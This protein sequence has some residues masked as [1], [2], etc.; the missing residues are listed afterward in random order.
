MS[1]FE[2]IE[3]IEK[4]NDF[5]R[6]TSIRENVI[7]WYD[8][9]KDS[10]ILE[11]GSDFGQVSK[12]FVRNNFDI[13]S[14]EVDE[15]R[16]EYINSVIPE[17]SKFKLLNQNLIEFKNT[18]KKYDYILITTSMS[19]IRDFVLEEKKQDA[20]LKLLE[21][22]YNLLKENGI[23]LLATD[24]K[25][26]IRI[27]SGATTKNTNSYDILTG[28]VK[29][30]GVFSKKEIIK[31]IE[32]SSFK[33]YKFYYPF[34]DYKLPSVIYSDEY[35]PNKNSSKLSYLLYYNPEDTI[36]FNEAEVLKEIIKD[37]MPD[38]FSNSYI[39]EIAKNKEDFCKA[40]FVSFNNF[41][42]KTSK[43]ITKIYTDYVEKQSIF[44]EGKEHIENIRK[45]IEILEKCGFDVIDEVIDKKLYSKFQSIDNLNDILS[46]YILNDNIDTALCIID[47][48][49]NYIKEKFNSII[50]TDNEQISNNTVFEKYNIDID[51]KLKEELTFLKD[52]F[53]DIIFENIFT[54]LDS[55]NNFEK[56][57]VY[58]QEWCEKNLPL[59]FILYRAINNLFYYNPKIAK[60]LSI[61]TLY[62]RYKIEKFV[63]V[64]KVLEEKIQASLLDTYISNMYKS[65]YTS[66]TTLEALQETIY[67]SKISCQDIKKQYE[68]FIKTVEKTNAQWQVA[69]DESNRKIERL[70]KKLKEQNSLI[71]SFKN[72]FKK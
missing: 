65:T 64:F 62:N 51:T 55:S 21:I 42:K 36:V 53:F 35:L 67:Y 30:T 37:G 19:R 27:F 45:Y 60:C 13:T 52:G 31:L 69:L 63:D 58:D 2:N 34:P 16:C 29:D 10:S 17:S 15:K 50:I 22:S 70:E 3:L 1:R 56:F 28:K 24:N 66:L 14:L 25:Y 44:E 20:F 39:I 38:Y 4:F 61:E 72:L 12:F 43:M 49:Y 5:L 18:D 8:F 54:K 9:K 41:R 57:L 71:N 26:G 11:I 59:Q 68:D 33:N 23:I 7:N 6:E 46:E 47:N 32:S 40:K 48:W